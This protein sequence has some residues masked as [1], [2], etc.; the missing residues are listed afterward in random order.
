MVLIYFKVSRT[1]STAM[2]E[3]DPTWTVWEF[4][5]NLSGDIST[6]FGLAYLHIVPLN[7]LQHVGRAAEDNAALLPSSV[8]LQELYGSNL[9]GFCC[10]V[11]PITRE[12]WLTT[13]RDPIYGYLVGHVAPAPNAEAEVVA[14]VQADGEVTAE[15]DMCITCCISDASFIFRP[16]NHV[17]MCHACA[18]RVVICPICRCTLTN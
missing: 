8:T 5:Q 1:T 9:D 12:L 15:I 10:Y 6:V 11:R 18:S 2:F 4:L 14:Q 16:C 3:T 7:Q 17:C 13:Y